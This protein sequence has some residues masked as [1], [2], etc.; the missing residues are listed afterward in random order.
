MKKAKKA[1]PPRDGRRSHLV[2]DQWHHTI[3]TVVDA[4]L[5]GDYRLQGTPECVKRLGA[6][7]ATCIE[8]TLKGYGERLG[9][10][11]SEAWKTSVCHWL[12][13]WWEVYVDLW[14][15]SA[16]KTD[17]VL[18]MRVDEVNE[19]FRFAVKSVHVP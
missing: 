2:P 8:R 16:E 17:L 10:L 14:T 4:L 19:E 5:E 9:P 7:D 3:A 18:K 1:G 13:G 15:A 11:P 12:D 6:V